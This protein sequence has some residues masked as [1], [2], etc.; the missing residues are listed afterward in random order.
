LVEFFGITTTI[1]G[2]KRIQYI[3]ESISNNDLSEIV[4]KIEWIKNYWGKYAK[5]YLEIEEVEN[6][7]NDI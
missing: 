2:I 4:L 7:I 1:K 3:F 6:F 5:D